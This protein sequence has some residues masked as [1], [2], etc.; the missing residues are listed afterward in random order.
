MM[1]KIILVIIISILIL[2]ISFS[3]D[4][5]M[6]VSINDISFEIDLPV[7][8]VDNH[9]MVPMKATFRK[10]GAKIYEGDV[11]T[12]YYLN[13]FVKA[14]P[15]IHEITI[16][17]NPLHHHTE[18]F[19]QNDDLYVPIEVLVKAFDFTMTTND[20]QSI[21][22]EA[23]STIQYTNYDD[24]HYQEIS[25]EKE[26][27][28]LSLPIFWRKMNEYI[29]GYDSSYGQI[30]VDLSTRALNDNIDL[31]YIINVYREHL[32][33]AYEDK[34]TFTREEQNIYNYLT[35]NVL[36]IDLDVNGR[37]VK[38][39]VHFIQTEN[40]VHVIEFKYP[41]ELSESYMHETFNNIMDSFYIDSSSFDSDKEHYIE[42]I[43]ARNFNMTLSS[44]I[45][46]NMTVED[47]FII[48]GYFNTDVHV[49]ALVI[50]VT[51]GSNSLEFY[52]PVEN[53][54]FYSQI[55]TPFGLGKHNIKVAISGEEEK[56]I[57]DPNKPIDLEPHNINLLQFSV[58]NLSKESQKYIIPT[59]FVQSN[60]SKIISMSNLLTRKYQ[61]YYSKAKA[62]F[63]FVA[64]DID[65]LVVNDT[66][67][68][69]VDVYENFKGTKKEIAFYLA[70]LLRAQ[71]IQ[72]KIVEGNND[73]TRHIWVE[74]YLNGEW[75]ILDPIG[76]LIDLEDPTRGEVFI[77]PS[78]FN[79][80]RQL[81]EVRYNNI[82][83]LE[84]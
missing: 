32:L 59:K 34:V 84:H 7:L 13:T 45:Y 50:T 54:A 70:A 9:V 23:N 48:E 10:L 28:R 11:I 66:N 21:N 47:Q 27:I 69:A 72:A 41:S 29:Y 60:H 44:Q 71:N 56:I 58:V 37:L 33:M 75:I 55:Y 31:E 15:N 4:T 40:E 53:N 64:E 19:Y 46:S 81:Y 79:A 83:I 67:Y 62:I 52:I 26:G 63:D 57:F 36:Y 2:S 17:G 77:I 65:V 82:K 42:F 20:D 74:A 12:S 51:R 49:D 30:T 68:T 8:K 76:D 5:I 16:N 24:I 38:Q 6:N 61:T 80:N 35:S 39:I 25:F 14:S 43:A 78:K 1:K 73:Y 22:L 18:L 3:E